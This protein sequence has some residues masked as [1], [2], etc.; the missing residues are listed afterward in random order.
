LVAS[1]IYLSNYSM[2]VSVSYES[3]VF[4]KSF[5]APLTFSLVYM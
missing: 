3:P 4:R 5:N 2:L 1:C